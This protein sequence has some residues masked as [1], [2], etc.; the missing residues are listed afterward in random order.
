MSNIP[1]KVNSEMV[2]SYR[3]ASPIGRLARIC[4]ALWL[5][6]A[7]ESSSPSTM[8]GPSVD[9]A[10]DTRVEA[11]PNDAGEDAHRPQPADVGLDVART[12]QPADVGTDVALDAAVD[13]GPH[14][15]LTDPTLAT[16]TAPDRYI[17]R[18]ETTQGEVIIEVDRSSAPRG[19]D[20]FYN[21]VR[22][23]YYDNVAVFRVV[24]EFVAQ[25]GIHGDPAVA[26]VWHTATIPDDPVVESN[27]RGTLTYATAGA[28]TRTTQLFINLADNS[29]LDARGFAPFGVVTDMTAIDQLYAGYGDGDGAPSQ[30]RIRTEGNAYLRASFPE[31]DYIVRAEII[32]PGL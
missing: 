30:T 19:A 11:P 2:E 22:I 12:P 9:S 18:L 1:T 7:C 8:H 28:G 5:M 10:A 29:A 6:M 23:G 13:A 26:A 24:A 17:V 32:E 31:L 14:P 27:V 16:E 4:A 3:L 15:A 21:L 25:F 20:R